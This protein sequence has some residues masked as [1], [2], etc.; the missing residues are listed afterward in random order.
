MIQEV[1]SEFAA[2]SE[3]GLV[4]PGFV[5]LNFHYIMS[6]EEFEYRQ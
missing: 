3:N 1:V 6:E 2:E 4:R 5:R